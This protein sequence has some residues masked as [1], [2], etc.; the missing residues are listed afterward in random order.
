MPKQPLDKVL[1]LVLAESYNGARVLL[2]D[3]FAQRLAE[4][5]RGKDSV[6]KLHRWAE[7]QK[8]E[9]E[10][11]LRKSTRSLQAVAPVHTDFFERLSRMDG[12]GWRDPP[13][14]T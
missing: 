8:S 11:F 10:S 3:E 13:K 7:E 6:D 14:E 9:A 2:F 1:Q 4:V 5:M 12:S